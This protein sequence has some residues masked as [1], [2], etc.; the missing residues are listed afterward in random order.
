MLWPR[1]YTMRNVAVPIALKSSA[2]GEFDQ[3]G[4]SHRSGIEFIDLSEQTQPMI[5]DFLEALTSARTQV[6]D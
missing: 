5:G 4:L 3:D 1:R 2:I 6:L